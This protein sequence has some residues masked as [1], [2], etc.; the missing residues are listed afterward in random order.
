MATSPR[1]SLRDHPAVG[2]FFGLL[3]RGTSLDASPQRA[4]RAHSCSRRLQWSSGG[5]T[6]ITRSS[7]LL[8]MS[9]RRAAQR[10]IR[11]SK[12]A[13]VT[14]DPAIVDGWPTH[15]VLWLEWG[16]STLSTPFRYFSTSVMA[17]TYPVQ[18]PKTGLICPP[19]RTAGRTSRRHG[20]S[21]LPDLCFYKPT[22][23]NGSRR[24]GPVAQM[25]RAAVS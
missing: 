5:S 16:S 9:S 17:A 24:T 2:I 10:T 8:Y 1:W 14:V 6:S 20:H 4:V 7:T 12:S 3:F 23:H 18:S 25:D 22:W 15:A 19:V 11:C 21:S 13:R